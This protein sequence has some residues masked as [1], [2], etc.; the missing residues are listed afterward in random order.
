MM[1]TGRR[2]AASAPRTMHLCA[3]RQ[4]RHGDMDYGSLMRATPE[5]CSECHAGHGRWLPASSAAAMVD[6]YR[7]GY[8]GHVWTLPKGQPDGHR[9]AATSTE[10]PAP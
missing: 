1:R 8:C 4:P 2:S 5:L 3:M 9:F 7:C 10:S 6:Y